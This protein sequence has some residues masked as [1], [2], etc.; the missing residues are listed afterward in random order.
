MESSIAVFLKRQTA[1]EP[2]P[3]N[4]LDENKLQITN[5]KQ[6]MS[7]RIVHADDWLRFPGARID[8]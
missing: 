2:L 7:T 3:T 6:V 1:Y 8:I 4:R 5:H